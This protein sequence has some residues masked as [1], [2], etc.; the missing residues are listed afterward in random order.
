M[1]QDTVGRRPTRTC[2][3]PVRCAGVTLRGSSQAHRVGLVADDTEYRGEVG[4][5]AAVGWD[6]IAKSPNVLVV[7]RNAG[8]AA[9]RMEQDPPPPDVAPKSCPEGLVKYN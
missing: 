9:D 3:P 2:R 1:H 5:A 6:D 4:A 8:R 7:D